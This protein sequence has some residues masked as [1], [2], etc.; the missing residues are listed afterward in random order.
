M[1]LDLRLH[2]IYKDRCLKYY[3][4]LYFDKCKVT[5]ALN[6]DLPVPK[7]SKVEEIIDANL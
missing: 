3:N 7:S 2:N 6:N 5:E 1:D 4:H